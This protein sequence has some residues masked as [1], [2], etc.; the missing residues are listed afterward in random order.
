MKT[1][2]INLALAALLAPFGGVQQIPSTS[3][4]TPAQAQPATATIAPCNKGTQAQPHK[5]GWAEKKLKAL[6]CA[7]NKNLCDLPSSP[8]EITGA[9]PDAKPCPP[10]AP[11]TPAPPLKPQVQASPTPATGQATATAGG[12]PTFVCPPKTTLIPNTPYCLAADHT[13]VD[14]IPLPPSLAAPTP[15]AKTPAQTKPQQ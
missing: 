14:A 5:Q 3:Q 15:S 10:K 12:K 13:T 7:Q 2:I 9:T 8:S 1:Q 6:A 11:T 4:P